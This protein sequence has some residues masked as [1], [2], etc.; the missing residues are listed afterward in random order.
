MVQSHDFNLVI[1]DRPVYCSALS[2]TCTSE[3]LLIKNQYLEF[4]NKGKLDL[5]VS[6][7]NEYYERTYPKYE[8]RHIE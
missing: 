2:D 1:I 3:A 7:N 5:V 6:G 4:I 8:Y